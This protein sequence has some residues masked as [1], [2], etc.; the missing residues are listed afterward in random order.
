MAAASGGS[1]ES[2]QQLLPQEGRYLGPAA[3][4]GSGTS[5][6][7]PAAAQQAM[8]RKDVSV[9]EAKTNDEVRRLG[10]K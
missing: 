7:V 2:V 1:S 8:R 3:A 9:R 6:P 10:A 4:T 5:T